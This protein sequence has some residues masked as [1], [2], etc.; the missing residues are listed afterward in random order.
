MATIEYIPKEGLD[1][2]YDSFW[3][4][5]D[6]CAG[7]EVSDNCPYRYEE[8]ELVTFTPQECIDKKMVGCDKLVAYTRFNKR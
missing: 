4:Q 6:S 7:F 3:N 1:K 2:K 8:M 5:T